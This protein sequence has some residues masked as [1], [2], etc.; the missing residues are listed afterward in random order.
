M[1]VVWDAALGV[2]FMGNEGTEQ[3][4]DAIELHG[5]VTTLGLVLPLRFR[6]V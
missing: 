1:V 6:L 2:I 4:K 5:A 3:G